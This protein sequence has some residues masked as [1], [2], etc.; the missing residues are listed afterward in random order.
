MVA[1]NL[2]AYAESEITR[3]GLGD[4]KTNCHGVAAYDHAAGVRLSDGVGLEVVCRTAAEVDAELGV[5]A[6]WYAESAD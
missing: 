2:L 3:L 5:M 4:S 6:D 1:T